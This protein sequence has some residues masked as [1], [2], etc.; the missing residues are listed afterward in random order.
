MSKNGFI[1]IINTKE[2]SIHLFIYLVIE[3]FSFSFFI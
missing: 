1:D 3:N 2:L